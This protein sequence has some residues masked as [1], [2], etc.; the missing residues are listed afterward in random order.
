[1]VEWWNSMKSRMRE[2][3]HV[4]N[5][6]VL[7]KSVELAAV[8]CTAGRLDFA[9]ILLREELSIIRAR[10]TPFTDCPSMPMNIIHSVAWRSRT[11][12]DFSCICLVLI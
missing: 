10:S 5:D 9:N 7:G 12:Q 2:G 4:A 8:W 11:R 1:M 3:R 6:V